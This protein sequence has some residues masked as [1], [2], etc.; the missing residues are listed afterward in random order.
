MFVEG[1]KNQISQTW[2]IKIEDSIEIRQ[3][4][5]YECAWRSGFG[6]MGH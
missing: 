1:S 6:I 3:N 2:E 4:N 5:P